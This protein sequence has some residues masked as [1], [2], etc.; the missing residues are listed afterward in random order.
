MV[1]MVS[2]MFAYVQMPSI[3]HIKY[4][5]FLYMNISIKLLKLW[6]V[7]NLQKSTENSVITNS[8][9]ATT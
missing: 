2:W 9:L 8:H 3:V 4:V 7:W 6:N 5:Q 1:M